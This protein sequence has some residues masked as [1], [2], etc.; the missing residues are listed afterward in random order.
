MLQMPSW[1]Q[2][3]LREPFVHFAIL[4]GL[5]FG[6]YALARGGRGGGA[7]GDTGRAEPDRRIVIGAADLEALRSSFR[8]A[9]RREPT[10]DELG[11]Q[12]EAFV[13]DEVLFRE[14]K[15]LALDRDDVVVRRRL[16]EKMSALARPQSPVAD[17]SRSELQRWYDRYPHRFAQAGRLS[18]EQRFFDGKRRADATG[19]ARAALGA[20]A[21][22]DRT[23]ATALG[24]GDDFVLPAQMIEKT[25]VQVAHLYGQEFVTALLAAPL[26]TWQGPVTSNFGQHLVFVIDRLPARQPPFAE[27]EKAVRADWLTVNTRGVKPAAEA[28]LPRYRVVLQGEA[29]QLAAAPAVAP[30]LQTADKGPGR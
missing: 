21:A 7:G 20:L 5:I 26:R 19:D 28:L 9:W 2:R 3:L 14:G 22:E 29:A 30:L 17:P 10:R 27:V 11:D 25:D 13:H 1:A 15:S 18:F 16:I 6:V 23:D 4:G 24:P 8:V 12:V